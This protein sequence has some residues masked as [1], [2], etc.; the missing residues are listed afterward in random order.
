LALAGWKLPRA[1][2][3]PSTDVYSDLCAASGATDGQKILACDLY[4][5]LLLPMHIVRI[6]L[7]HPKSLLHRSLALSTVVPVVGLMQVGKC[8][9]FLRFVTY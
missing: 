9:H 1:L 7:L 6:Q 2:V 4:E 8:L 5:H 3:A